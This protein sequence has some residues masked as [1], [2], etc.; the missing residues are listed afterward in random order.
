MSHPLLRVNLQ[1]GYA[2]QTVLHEVSFDLREDERLG[3]VGSSGAGKSTLLLALLGLLPWKNGWANGEV[4]LRGVNLLTLRER[5]ARKLRGKVV[6]LI[7]QSPLTA[8]NSALSLRAH[9]VE[10]WRAHGGAAR[11]LQPRLCQ[12]LERVHL[13]ADATFLKRKPGEISVGQAQRVTIALALLHR[14]RL[15]IADEPTSALDPI[16]QA[17]VLKLL[18]DLSREDGAALLYISHDLLSVLQLCDRVALLDCGRIAECLPVRTIEQD[19]KHPSMRALLQT[20]PAPVDVL[21]SYAEKAGKDVAGTC[22]SSTVSSAL[23]IDNLRAMAFHDE[24]ESGIPVEQRANPL[25]R[26]S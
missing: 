21:L 26:A 7:P 19:S 12:L 6:S 8:L 17:E 4:L 5:E 9:F 23:H 22:S 10:A 20:L 2:K 16:T 11:D 14:P 3:M 25:Q 24:R 15:L 13:P 18:R 1:A